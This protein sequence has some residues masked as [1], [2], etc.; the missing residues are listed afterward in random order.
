MKTK[1][2]ISI[3]LVATM[4]LSVFS[5]ISSANEASIPQ[6]SELGLTINELNLSCGDDIS[7]DESCKLSVEKTI[8][9]SETSEEILDAIVSSE[10]FEITGTVSKNGVNYDINEY[11]DFE[12]SSLKC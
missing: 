5:V 10:K 7:N 1:K 4:L 12:N 9:I 11:F 8:Q 2:I 3:V 6:S